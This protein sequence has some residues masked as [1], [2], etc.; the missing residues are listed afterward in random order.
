MTTPTSSTKSTDTKVANG[1]SSR[2]TD[3]GKGKDQNAFVSIGLKVVGTT[4]KAGNRSLDA[5][6]KALDS[7]LEYHSAI[8]A[9]TNVEWVST[10]A[11]AQAKLAREISAATTAASRELLK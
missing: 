5:Y 3:A 7:S 2:A 11:D 6:E 10:I 8:A 1:N 9:V 4:K